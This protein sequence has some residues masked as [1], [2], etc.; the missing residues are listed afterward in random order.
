[1][2]MQYNFDFSKLL[3]GA[4]RGMVGAPLLVLPVGVK[5]VGVNW[6]RGSGAED[7]EGCWALWP[8]RVIRQP[9]CFHLDQCFVNSWSSLRRYQM[10][11]WQHQERREKPA[12]LRCLPWVI[13][14]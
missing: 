7:W 10:N 14:R 13:D 2:V 5:E 11:T 4:S 12:R 3:K 9:G 1:M 8:A 6:S